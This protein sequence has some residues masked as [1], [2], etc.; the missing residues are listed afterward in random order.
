MKT[1]VV[2]SFPRGKPVPEN[3]RYLRSEN[4][5]VDYIEV[6]HMLPSEPVYAVHDVYEVYVNEEDDDSSVIKTYQNNMKPFIQSMTKGRHSDKD[7]L[8][9]KQEEDTEGTTLTIKVQKE[10]AREIINGKHYS[11]SVSFNAEE[12]QK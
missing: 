12:E 2:Q 8:I 1:K 9:L 3:S 10:I 5:I 4:V 11:F 7:V 6:H